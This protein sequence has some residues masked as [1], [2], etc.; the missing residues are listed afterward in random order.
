MLT[1]EESLRQLAA[2]L[3][4]DS[5]VALRITTHLGAM[6]GSQSVQVM[7]DGRVITSAFVPSKGIGKQDPPVEVGTVEPEYVAEVAKALLAAGAHVAGPEPAPGGAEV[8][9]GV[10]MGD[11]RQSVR[12]PSFNAARDPNFAAAMKLFDDAK[13]RFGAG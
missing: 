8:E 3:R 12:K 9:L 4:L 7:S 11:V 6:R 5:V 13:K 1:V 10:T 2:G